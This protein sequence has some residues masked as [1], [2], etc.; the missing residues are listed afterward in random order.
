MDPRPR[1]AV[2]SIEAAIVSC[3]V[4]RCYARAKIGFSEILV[5]VT[6][7]IAGVPLS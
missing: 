4:C 6:C 1:V 2:A 3:G 7:L 5:K